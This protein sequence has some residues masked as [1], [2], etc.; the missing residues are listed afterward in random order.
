MG[1]CYQ[2]K[3]FVAAAYRFLLASKFCIL[4]FHFDFSREYR[5]SSASIRHSP[6][7][8]LKRP[9]HEPTVDLA[10]YGLPCSLTFTDAAL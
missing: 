7:D 9:G 10:P 6:F 4:S 3:L 2:V 8:P 1:H 5:N